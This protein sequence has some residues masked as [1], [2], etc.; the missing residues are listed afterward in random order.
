M[1]QF[2]P[3]ITMAILGGAVAVAAMFF[4]FRERRQRRQESS[5]EGKATAGGNS[6]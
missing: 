3:A 2:L 5:T 1:T 6:G 4:A